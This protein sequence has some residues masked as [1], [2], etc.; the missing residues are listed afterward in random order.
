[1]A[2][3]NSNTDRR[4]GL[5]AAVVED[6]LADETRRVA[7]VILADRD[8][9]MV[10]ESLATAVRAAVDDT[11]ADA[12]TAAGRDATRE[13]LFTDHIPKLTATGVVRYDSML[14]TV[15]LVRPDIVE[16]QAP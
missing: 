10:V 6:L 13:K 11:P 16:E 2:T 3:T 15:E 1:M 12:V 7:L 9:P 8:E 4:A 14:G 5:P